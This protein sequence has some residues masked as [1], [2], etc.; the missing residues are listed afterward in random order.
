MTPDW[1]HPLYWHR[2]AWPFQFQD[3][4]KETYH[5][6]TGKW[7]KI[8]KSHHEGNIIL[9]PT[10]LF[11]QEEK[12]I[13]SWINKFQISSQLSGGEKDFL[14]SIYTKDIYLST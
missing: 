12:E 11:N 5:F 4:G 13:P 6:Q 10:V 3:N 9:T 8:C 2:V 1:P 7:K 14:T